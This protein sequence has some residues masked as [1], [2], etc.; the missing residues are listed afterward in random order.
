MEENPASS[1]QPLTITVLGP[2]RLT[3]GDQALPL[4]PRS[5]AHAL[6]AYLLL[7]HGRAIERAYLASQ[8]D[9]D[10][11]DVVARRRLSDTLYLLR[12]AIPGARLRA[13]PDTLALALD[14][15]DRCDLLI[16]ERCLGEQATPDDHARLLALPEPHFCPELEH[17]WALA[18]REEL[19]LRFL[20]A[21]ERR[22]V[23][24]AEQ[25]DLPAARACLLRLVQIEPVRET[26]QVALLH[27]FA[28]L[29]SPAEAAHQYAQWKRRLEREFGFSPEPETER[30]YQQVL[31]HAARPAPPRQDLL[32][33]AL[34]LVGRDAERRRA[35]DWIDRA[36]PQA[37]L[38]LVEG[39]AGIGKS[40]LLAHL[41]EDA[42]WRDWQ[43]ASA[44]AGAG[45]SAVEA[46]L[47]ALLSPLQREQIRLQMPEIWW[48]RLLAIFP[49]A[50]AAA[51]DAGGPE[52]A[53]YHEVILRLIEA[54][55]AHA[56]LLLILDDMHGAG[57]SDLALLPQIAALT[58][59]HP[60]LVLVSYRSSVRDDPER[61][62]ALRRLDA[63]A[64]GR[65]LL[66]DP[67]PP[68]QCAA[69]LEQTVGPCAPAAAEQ[70]ARF[71]GGH[72]LFL[73]ETLELLAER[74]A[75][76][77]GDAGAWGFDP[78]A[79]DALH[80]AD[81]GQAIL[82]RVRSLPEPER[83][84]LA[85]AAV[86]GDPLSPAQLARITGGAPPA[87]VAQA[88]GL[89]RRHLLR[90]GA[91]GYSCA[92]ALIGQ[93]ARELIGPQACQ[94]WH[95]R[96]FAAVGDQPAISAL[97]R[98]E[99]AL[100]AGLWDA[101]LP[102]L[103]RASAEA[104]QR[105]DYRAALRIVNQAL[106]ALTHGALPP[107]PRAA[108]QIDLL[109]ERLLVW[110]WHPPETPEQPAADLALLDRLIPAAHPLRLRL[111]IARIDT[112]FDQG[113]YRAAY[114]LARAQLEL[115]GPQ[116]DPRR[117]LQLHL[118]L[119]KAAQ[120]LDAPAEGAA[121]L[122]RAQELA[123]A[124]GETEAEVAALGHLAIAQHFA[125]DF[126]AA[127]AGY[128][129]VSQ[130]CERHGLIMAGLVASANLAALEQS[131][132]HLAAAIRGYERT[133]A[134]C[135]RYAAADPP[136][137]ENLAEICIQVGAFARAEALLARAE[138]L[139]RERGGSWALTRCRQ[140]VLAIARQRFDEGRA[141]LDA[142]RQINTAGGDSRV[143]G[144]IGLWQALIDIEQGRLA[145][146]DPALDEA[147]A[148]YRQMGVGLYAALIAALRAIAAA[149]RGQ[150][151]RAR[152]ALDLAEAAL[153]QSASTLVDP[154]YLLG[155]T[156]EIL[157]DT[158]RATALFQAAW[159]DLQAQAAAL[160]PEL[161][162]QLWAAPFSRRRL[163][164]ARRRAAGRPLVTLPL[165]TAPT[166]RP[167]H[168]WEEVAV[169]W[170][171]P[172]GPP[173]DR[174]RAARR[175]AL[176]ALIEQAHAQEAAPTLAA[177]AQALA[178]SAATISRDLR[179]LGWPDGGGEPRRANKEWV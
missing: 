119:G 120:V 71:T 177:L 162:A 92:H 122:R 150:I 93:A 137:L 132:G 57:D 88:Q 28:A 2:L 6:L 49:T 12:R 172:E 104:R 135:E 100:A 160:P 166:G 126:A 50:A 65:R 118:Q 131:Q 41:A 3:R 39:M 1:C 79:L 90:T 164:A 4:V 161:A 101:A 53:R 134:S 37:S 7:H 42:R 86:H 17:D 59:Q 55:T 151:A 148:R 173:A 147:E 38:A 123:A 26:A 85:A 153:G 13:G 117:L 115:L 56:P 133:I 10:L 149:R 46:A 107:A 18:A 11:P 64:P 95:A 175:R 113:A 103:A 78:Q 72:P 47:G 22:A 81:A 32:P 125:G 128:T 129:Q 23:A 121:H 179:E 14:P 30:R 163:W 97:R 83:A 69:L 114:D 76:R 167:L 9:P 105:A 110:H 48:R 74:G 66:L 108:R 51:P 54:L 89:V 84:I 52:P 106:E 70:L 21:L 168:P 67:L 142:T 5:R 63:L 116:A 140:A 112:L 111:A 34:P 75:L 154:R 24:A 43:V 130:L 109:F 20:G 27:V 58:T 80:L 36:G 170:E 87:V 124:C 19:R 145:R 61:W 91:A 141:L 102:L 144:E 96:I 152:A 155:L 73:R 127:R 146:I 31:R 82:A 158:A 25:G 45:G 16:L 44:D 77:R 136:D 40:H 156:A 29:G 171:L 60:L 165:K 68:A 169:L 8:L 35:L 138:A 143:A 33:L 159:Q 62:R 98:G 176:L 157:G 99:H 174:D 139:W 15:C 178:V 94:A